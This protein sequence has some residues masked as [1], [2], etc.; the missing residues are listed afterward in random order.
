MKLQGNAKDDFHR[1]QWKT[2]E[3]IGTKNRPHGSPNLILIICAWNTCAHNH[4]KS[5]VLRINDIDS[6][7][8]EITTWFCI[9]SVVRTSLHSK[10]C[11]TVLQ[12]FTRNG[13]HKKQASKLT[14]FNTNI[15][16]V[17][18]VWTQSHQIIGATHNLCWFLQGRNYYM[19][20]H[21]FH[22]T[23]VSTF[24]KAH[25]DVVEIHMKIPV[26]ITGQICKRI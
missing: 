3:K 25:D 16:C 21:Q 8:G 14:W 2:R 5:L 12:K 7:R 6:Y 24:K 4:T 1:H 13:Q 26:E 19:I 11:M 18:I 20:L 17:K 23:H 22:R 15:L 10:Q 9:I